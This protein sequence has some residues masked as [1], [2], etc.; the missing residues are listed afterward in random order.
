MA[1]LSDHKA[2]DQGDGLLSLHH[3][4]S[5]IRNQYKLIICKQ[6]IRECNGTFPIFLSLNVIIIIIIV[7]FEQ[8]TCI[9]SLPPC[10]YE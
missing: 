8:D 10:S 6:C 5:I 2:Q 4:R 9:A 1:G 7:Y 3:Q